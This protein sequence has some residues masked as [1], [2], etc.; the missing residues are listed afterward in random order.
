MNFQQLEYIVAVD[1][2]K[3][4]SRAAEY[5]HITQATLSMMVK[6]LEEELNTV[7]F[8]RKINPIVT[9]ESGRELIQQAKKILIES[10]ELKTIAN[11]KSYSVEGHIRLA[12]IPTIANALLPK[13]LSPILTKYPKLNLEILE[14]TTDNII[15]WLKLGKIDMGILSTPLEIFNIEE[16]VLYYEILLVYGEKNSKKKYMMIDEIKKQKIWLLEEGNCLRNQMLNIC[17]LKEKETLFTNLKFEANSFEMLLNM[18]DSMGGL[19]L[20]PELYY[21]LLSDERKKK[22]S[23]FH[24]RIPVREV[25]L[26][27]FRPFAKQRVIEAIS[28]EIQ[29]IIQPNLMSNKHKKHTLEIAKI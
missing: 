17:T 29:A 28:K 22:V 24:E 9:T 11:N 12:V 13:I 14:L 18:I 3:S 20:I 15:E 5:C 27:Y 6:R 10:N 23:F 16:K 2:F 7:I 8:D 4:F 25:S 19:T 26:V 1:Q 21:H